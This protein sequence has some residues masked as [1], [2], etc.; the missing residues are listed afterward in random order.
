MP[1]R[2]YSDL[3]LLDGASCQWHSTCAFTN[4]SSFYATSLPM[5]SAQ[6][7]VLVA[8]KLGPHGLQRIQTFR[9]YNSG[10]DFGRGLPMSEIAYGSLCQ[11]L[12]QIDLPPTKRPSVFLTAIGNL[13][14]AWENQAGSKIQAEFSPENIEF[15]NEHTGA[16]GT[17]GTT[18]VA[19][20]AGLLAS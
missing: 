19:Q 20:V 18:E 3:P 14:L 16:E 17:V 10:W 12:R 11:F 8:G 9:D 4:A 2:N 15:Y 1:S 7:Q 6:E 5:P 13:E